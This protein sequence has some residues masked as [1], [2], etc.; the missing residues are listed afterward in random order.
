MAP[1]RAQA[2]NRLAVDQFHVVSFCDRDL[3]DAFELQQFALDHH[4]R[5]IDQQIQ[6]REAA[7]PHRHLKRLH[8]QP[9]AR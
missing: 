9:V 6:H 2:A 8:V 4:L 5:Q 1:R 3:A 7:L